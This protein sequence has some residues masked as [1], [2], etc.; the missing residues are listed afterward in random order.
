M[1]SREQYE[2]ASKAK[3]EAQATIDAYFKQEAD[4][5]AERLR[6]HPIFADEELTYSATVKCVCG[7]GLAYPKACG[8]NHYW[9]C[10]AE[11]KGTANQEVPHT[12]HLPF[13]FYEL[14][15][16]G[17]PSANGAT[18]RPTTP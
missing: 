11:L 1:I 9:A 6:V 7:A 12:G 4:A 10:S 3:T 18:T 16:E 5:F 8:M 15:S 2:A 14:K 17:Q 13:A